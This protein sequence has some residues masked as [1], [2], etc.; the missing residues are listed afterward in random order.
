MAAVL[1]VVCFRPGLLV[2]MSGV[3]GRL[4]VKLGRQFGWLWVAYSVSALGTYLAFDAF[5]VIAV[6]ALRGDP[7]IATRAQRLRMTAPVCP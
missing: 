4:C 5:S 2:F 3:N 1:L 6:I 7:G